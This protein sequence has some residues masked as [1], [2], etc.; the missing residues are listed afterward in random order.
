MNG[1][2]ALR[3]SG[4]M[5]VLKGSKKKESE[6]VIEEPDSDAEKQFRE[7]VNQHTD[8]HNKRIDLCEDIAQY[9]KNNGSGKHSEGLQTS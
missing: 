9:I 4:M 6:E 8:A 3:L 1:T 5:R 2:L 7:S